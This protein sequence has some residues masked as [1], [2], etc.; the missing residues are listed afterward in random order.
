MAA[1]STP[2]SDDSPDKHRGNIWDD[3]ATAPGISMLRDND[4]VTSS[5]GSSPNVS[6]STYDMAETSED[7]N[8]A[9]N[10]PD[11]TTSY[12]DWPSP[13]EE[14]LRQTES[15]PETPHQPSFDGSSSKSPSPSVVAVR[16]K[17]KPLQ[18]ET[19]I[20]LPPTSLENH[21]DIC[22]ILFHNVREPHAP[23][24][25]QC[26]VKGLWCDMRIPSCSRCE[27]TG[28]GNLC[29]L[30]R[31]LFS[32]EQGWEPF[33]S[34]YVLLRLR[35]CDEVWQEKLWLEERVGRLSASCFP[36]LTRA[37]RGF[38]SR[39]RRPVQLGTPQYHGQPPEFQRQVASLQ[40]G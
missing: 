3:N 36:V 2:L 13:F 15:T 20:P 10:T 1:L 5:C 30:Q 7:D 4:S 21:E 11:T 28:N 32:Y 8:I 25:L 6:L 37:A 29:L 24:C 17:R 16:R 33:R 19:R 26:A 9:C 31:P 40:G 35:E 18:V 22:R 27:R 23:P 38:A 34:Q 39:S 14:S 12:H